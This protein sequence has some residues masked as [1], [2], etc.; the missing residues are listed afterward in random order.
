M[1]ILTFTFPG[2]ILVF[3]LAA[4]GCSGNAGNT[5]AGNTNTVPPINSSATSNA[6][7][8]S[9]AAPSAGGAYPE[10]VRDEFLKSCQGAGSDV[11]LC[12]CLLDKIQ[13]KY[14]FEEFT[15]MELKLSSGDPPEEFVQFVGGAKAQCTR[16]R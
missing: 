5:N 12:T 4:F 16:N 13:A 14:S 10:E 7:G 6:V 11:K 1:K 9:V 8:N 15:V 2:L 3:C